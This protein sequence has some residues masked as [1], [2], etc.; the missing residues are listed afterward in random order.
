MK[1]YLAGSLF[2]KAEVNERL[3]EGKLLKEKFPEET[4]YNPI[5]APINDKNKLPTALDVFKGDYAEVLAS[6]VMICDLTNN[7]CGVAM[8]MGIA[9]AL[10]EAYKI[11]QEEVEKTSLDEDQKEALFEKM[12]EKGIKKHEILAHNSDIR[13]AT[14]GQYDDFFVPYGQNQF[15]IGGILYAK[16]KLYRSIDELLEDRLKPQK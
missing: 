1:G 14:S 11:F 5:E 13:L 6:D 15:V 16:G 7:D 9:L 8:E 4:W 12:A 3:R 10:N 2:N